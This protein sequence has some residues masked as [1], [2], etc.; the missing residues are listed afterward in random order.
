M[1]RHLAIVEKNH[2]SVKVENYWDGEALMTEKYPDPMW[3]ECEN[4]TPGSLVLLG[5]MDTPPRY[6]LWGDSHAMALSP[7]FNAFSCK[8]GINGIYINRKHT[9]LEGT[10]TALYPH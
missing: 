2:V 6:V 1:G 10:N 7:G 4:R 9:L 3:E 5:K 8:T